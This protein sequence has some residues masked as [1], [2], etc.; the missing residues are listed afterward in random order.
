MNKKILFVARPQDKIDPKVTYQMR[1]DHLEH[2]K[3]GS[4]QILIRV[5]Y[6]SLDPALRGWMNP[7]KSYLPPMEIGNVVRA[8]G[9]GIVEESAHK[10]FSKGDLVSGLLGWQ[11]YALIDDPATGLV[12]KIPQ[13]PGVAPSAFINQLGINGL[14]AYFGL[15]KVGCPRPGET[16]L[17]S[18]AAGGVGSIA[19]QLVKAW[20]CRAV[21]VAGGEEKCRSLISDFGFD[22]AVDYKKG[23]LDAAI[24][25]ACPKGVDVFFDNVGGDV[26]DA[27]LN[28]INRGARIVLCGCISQYNSSPEQY[29]GPR[30]YFWT[31]LVARAKMEGFIF[32]DYIPEF[33]QAIGELLGLM[34]EG[35]LKT[36]EHV[37]DGLDK[38]PEATNLLFTGGNHGKL[39]IRVAQLPGE[40]K[41]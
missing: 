21:G 28:H 23:S 19:G 12:N 31:L 35:K 10:D 32:T 29:Q 26:L 39:M 36:K 13:I 5:H 8:L 15:K 41:H 16:V 37:I 7:T 11:E 3:P 9:V 1:V 33:P 2:P 25:A 24:A 14:S 20:G 30:N 40:L 18:G 6:I 27:A 17:I 4:T 34:K 22:A 38:A